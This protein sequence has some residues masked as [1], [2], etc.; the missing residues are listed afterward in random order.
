[1]KI[2]NLAALGLVAMVAAPVNAANW[3]DTYLGY[4]YSTQFREPG[5]LGTLDKSRL[6]FSHVSGWDYGTNFL[7]VSMLA[8]SAKDPAQNATASTLSNHS[9][10]QPTPGVPGATEVYCVYRTSLNLGKIF[11]TDLSF[12]PVREVDFTAGFDFDSKDNQFASNKKFI[13]AGPQLTFKIDKGF[14]NLGLAACREKNYNG[15]ISDTRPYLSE[16]NFKT[17]Y[18]IFTAW[19]KNFDIGIPAVFKGW[20]NYI[21][22]KGPNGF[23]VETKP[24]TIANLYLLVDASGLFGRKKGAFMVGPGFEFWDNKFG[25]ATF[26]APATAAYANN[27]RVTALML[28]A[29]FHF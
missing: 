5:L 19:D 16:V 22:A 17:T 13:M 14:W 15:I 18:M 1:M 8:S 7:D 23:G 24:E 4:Q 28:S 9:A 29:E 6:E 12:G 3:S 27:Q 20:A 10:G 26:S 21:G 25:G 11:K 2:L